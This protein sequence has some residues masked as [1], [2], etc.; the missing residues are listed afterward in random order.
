M[1]IEYP[2]QDEQLEI[3]QPYTYGKGFSW[4]MRVSLA[5]VLF[6]GT[7]EETAQLLPV[8]PSAHHIQSAL[9][10]PAFRYARTMEIN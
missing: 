7:T 2:S 3:G 9:R 10:W 8:S 4:Y 6:L 5:D 1:L